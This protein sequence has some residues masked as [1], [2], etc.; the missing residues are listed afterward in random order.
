MKMLSSLL[1]LC[2]GNPPVTSGVLSQRANNYFFQPEQIISRNRRIAND[3]IY[4]GADVMFK[5]GFYW[6]DH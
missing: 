4:N 6:I 2:E 3:L 5:W 1:A